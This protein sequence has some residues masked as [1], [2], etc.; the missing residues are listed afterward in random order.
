[1]LSAGYD[2]IPEFLVKKCINNIKRTLAN[3]FNVSLS[4]GTFPD[5]LKL[6]KVIPLHKKGEHHDIKNYRPVSI[7]YVINMGISLYNKVRDQIKLRENFNSFKKEL[8]SFLL[9][10]SFYS[11]DE[12]ISSEF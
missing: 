7:S 11:V 3:I 9:K 12:F 6:A 5:R 10:H 4:S 1:M 8:K 2:E